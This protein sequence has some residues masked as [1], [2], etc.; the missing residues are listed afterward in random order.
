MQAALFEPPP[1]QPSKLTVQYLPGT[2]SSGPAPPSPRCYTLTHNDI[3][4]DLRLSIGPSINASQVHGFYTR[5]LRDEIVAQWRWQQGSPQLHV[6]CHVSGEERWLAPPQL[7][8]YVFRRE[9]TLVRHGGTALRART[10]Q[11]LQPWWCSRRPRW[12]AALEG[13]GGRESSVCRTWSLA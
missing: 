12:H 8:N 7:R 10:G 13:A 4:G 6:H 11:Y 5:L 3:T 1:F 2:S 9:M